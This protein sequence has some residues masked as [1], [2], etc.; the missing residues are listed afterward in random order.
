MYISW[1]DQLSSQ[2]Q[3]KNIISQDLPRWITYSPGIFRPDA[4]AKYRAVLVRIWGVSEANE[5]GAEATRVMIF[6][7]LAS[8]W[9]QANFHDLQKNQV[10]SHI[11]LLRSTILAVFPS[12]SRLAPWR[13]GGFNPS[14]RFQS[15]IFSC[16]GEALT[17]AGE[18]SRHH[19]SDSRDLKGA[20]NRLSDLLSSL[21]S[22]IQIKLQTSQPVEKK[23][24]RGYWDQNMQTT[25]LQKVDQLRQKFEQEAS[26]MVEKAISSTTG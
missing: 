22:T 9:N 25:W 6:N 17:Q 16:L 21:G 13:L 11:K 20:M 1:C 5:F 4:D 2:P 18:N 7:V 10:R 26:R 8:T 3:W 24:T 12:E 19:D 14:Q 23:G 15:E